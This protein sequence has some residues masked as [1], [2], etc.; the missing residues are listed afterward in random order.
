MQPDWNNT[1]W[2]ARR[3]M[4]DLWLAYVYSAL[5]FV[6]M[7]A[8][9]VAGEP[10]SRDLGH[11]I[12]MLILI[13]PVL[14]SRYMTWKLDNEVVRHQRFIVGQPIAFRT[15]VYAR[16][17]AMLVAGLINVPLYFVWFWFF[18]DGWSSFGAYLAWVAFW[19]GIALVGTAVSMVLEFA[20]S[21]R[22]WAI[23]NMAMVAV[24]FLIIIPVLIFTEVRFVDGSIDAANDHPWTMGLIGIVM[25]ALAVAGGIKLAERALRERDFVQ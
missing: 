11:P 23:I 20:C 6:L 15:I 14:S 4:R 9:M 1:L 10:A 25:G 19:C 5:Y 3:Q 8:V 7:G 18:D 17:V 21:V 2:L 13:Q 24:I 16:W 12:L 22:K